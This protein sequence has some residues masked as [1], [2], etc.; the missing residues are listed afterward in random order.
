MFNNTI[1]YQAT[2]TYITYSTVQKHNYFWGILPHGPENKAKPYFS[3]DKIKYYY[4][5]Q[6]ET[7]IITFMFI[8]NI[9]KIRQHIFF[10]KQ[11]L[12][13]N[14]ASYSG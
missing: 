7:L 9:L 3:N 6:L 10:K 13:K 4:D 12:N 5:Y 11:Y 2:A 8:L 14:L 1:S